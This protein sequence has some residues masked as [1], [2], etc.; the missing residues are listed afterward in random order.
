MIVFSKIKPTFAKK[1]FECLIVSH[2]IKLPIIIESK[3]WFQTKYEIYHC[4]LTNI[5][6]SD[7]NSWKLGL[8]IIKLVTTFIW[9]KPSDEYS[10]STSTRNHNIIIGPKRHKK[11]N[12]K[13]ILRFVTKDCLFC[14]FL[15]DINE[16]ETHNQ[17]S[18]CWHW[19]RDHISRSYWTRNIG[20]QRKR[21]IRWHHYWRVIRRYRTRPFKIEPILDIWIEVHVCVILRSDSH[22]H[23]TVS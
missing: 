11:K 13:Y 16:M 21:R 3:K 15:A 10:I 9:N 5:S 23:K 17:Y 18:L 8:I 14:K 4:P 20:E 1:L 19:F 6:G 22:L 2:F 7:Y 12:K